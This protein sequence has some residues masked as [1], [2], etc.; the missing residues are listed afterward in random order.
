[1]K[2]IIIVLAVFLL[3]V[4]VKSN[5]NFDNCVL[6]E[7]NNI[8]KQNKL[9]PVT[10]NNDLHHRAENH[11]NNLFV[12]S[13]TT[14]SSLYLSHYESK[15]N[16]TIKCFK[17]PIERYDGLTG[18]GEICHVFVYN[19]KGDVV[20]LKIQSEEIIKAFFNSPSHKKIMLNKESDRVILSVD[21]YKR[22]NF[23]IVYC[24]IFL[25]KETKPLNTND[26]E[27]NS[28]NLFDEI[29]LKKIKNVENINKCIDITISCNK[30]T[31]YTSSTIVKE[32]KQNSDFNT[33][34]ENKNNKVG[35][36]VDI[37]IKQEIKEYNIKICF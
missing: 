22:N 17:S 15:S 33:L 20:S 31:S 35:I 28:S 32:L 12:F 16:D 5:D 21:E 6:T 18:G 11:N 10:V 37:V 3:A 1:M 8:R 9:K 26:F 29:G 25:Y 4:D 13:D 19:S 14:G 30:N 7:L 2:T 24:T 34:F 27:V 23:V 36:D